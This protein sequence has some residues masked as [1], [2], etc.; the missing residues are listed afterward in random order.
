MPNSYQMQ[1]TKSRYLALSTSIQSD[2]NVTMADTDFTRAELMQTTDFGQVTPKKESDIDYAGKGHSFATDSQVIG[3]ASMWDWNGRVNDWNIGYLLAMVLGVDTYT[4][5]AGGAPNQHVLT[6]ADN[7]NLASMT[8]IYIEETSAIKRKMLDMA[9]KTLVLTASEQGSIKFKASWVGTGRYTDGAIAAKPALVQSP[10]YLRGSDA[11]FSLGPSGGALT[12]FYPRVRSFELTLDS[13][14]EPQLRC[15]AGIYA[16]FVANG[17]PTIKLKLQLDADSSADIRGYAEAN[18]ELG[19]QAVIPIGS[20]T[21]AHP[22][23]VT[24]AVPRLIIPNDQLS[25]QASKYVG[26]TIE[27]DDQ[28]ILKPAAAEIFTATLLN[29]ATQ[30]LLPAAS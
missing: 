4:L 22:L 12:S 16:A 28:S 5:G 15:G 11:Q 6:F 29:T 21:I 7:T 18:T 1:R 25:E 19:L 24:L 23:S 3:M 17:N 27:L 8:N 26:Y 2:A 9:L 30:Y 10:T 20:Q 14:V 13:G